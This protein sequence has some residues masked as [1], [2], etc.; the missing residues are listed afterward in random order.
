[1]FVCMF[2]VSCTTVPQGKS[3]DEFFITRYSSTP[4]AGQQS[5]NGFDITLDFLDTNRANLKNTIYGVLYNGM[6]PEKYA[7]QILNEG[8]Q[9]GPGQAGAASGS[10]TVPPEYIEAHKWTLNEP[11]LVISRNTY[12]INGGAHGL[13][14]DNFYTINTGT[15]ALIKLEDII[16]NDKASALN[17]LIEN[18]LQEYAQSV[19][20]MVLWDDHKISE[21]Y[22]A[23]DGLH[24]YWNVYEITAYAYSPVEIVIGWDQLDSLLSPGGK[25]MAMAFKN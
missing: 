21:F 24:F 9:V 25:I 20:N 2:L 11:F 10:Q 7:N 12:Y 1:M 13:P 16:Q 3:T 15:G 6:T 5:G 19:N 8:K 23:T 22:P 18:K 4:T 17:D 14:L